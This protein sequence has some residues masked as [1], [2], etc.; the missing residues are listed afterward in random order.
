MK[1]FFWGSLGVA[2]L[3]SMVSCGKTDKAQLTA[4]VNIPDG[5]VAY[6]R[7]LSLENADYVDTTKVLNGE[8]VFKKHEPEGL[9]GIE[10][11]MLFWPVFLNENPLS[12]DATGEAVKYTG[13]NVELFNTYSA[14]D[15]E[16]SKEIIPLKDELQQVEAAEQN[17]QTK[18]R[19]DELAKT[20]D[21]KTDAFKNKVY[22][23]VKK[24]PNNIYALNVFQLLNIT[25]ERIKDFSAWL[26]T[27]NKYQ[28]HFIM[29][30]VRE[31]IA[32]EN[33]LG[34]NNPFVDVA[35]ATVNGDSVRLSDFAG[36]GKPVL[37][38]VWASWC[39]GCLQGMPGLFDLYNKYKE[40]GFQIFCVSVDQS[41]EPWKETLERLGMPWNTNYIYTDMLAPQSPLRLYNSLGLPINVLIDGSGKIVGRGMKHEEL[42]TRLEMIFSMPAG[43]QVMWE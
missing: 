9:Y 24:Y 13:E 1:R 28:D 42:D 32:V 33:R 15:A 29:K 31:F 12:L 26:D 17:D 3:L 27:W 22:E 14:L 20:I 18:A 10:V 43:A 34:R 25:D 5:T 19:H 23:I 37:L 38:E 4:K 6:L 40:K 2:I 36:K 16:F 11:Q 8:I 41:V 30:Q 35:A 7:D 39:K 21:E